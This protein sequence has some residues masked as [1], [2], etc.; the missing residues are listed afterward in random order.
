MLKLLIRN[1]IIIYIIVYSFSCKFINFHTILEEFYDIT[2][3]YMASTSL[4]F[5]FSD[6]PH[7]DSLEKS[8]SIRENNKPINFSLDKEGK[9][10]SLKPTEGWKKNASY[11]F[12]LQGEV[13]IKTG[14]YNTFYI[15]KNFIYGSPKDIFTLETFIE[16]CAISNQNNLTFLFNQQIDLSSFV[17]NFTLT[18]SISYKTNYKG[19][20][21][22][23]I[24]TE[25]WKT[26]IRYKW[27]I[28]N[29]VSTN[30]ILLQKEYQGNFVY[31]EDIEF[32]TVTDVSGFSQ[33]MVKD[34]DS[35]KITFN[36]AMD[37]YSVA[38][39]VNIEPYIEGQL[40]S[41][42]E[43]NVF[44]WKPTTNWNIATDYTLTLDSSIADVSQLRLGKKYTYNFSV[45]DKYLQVTKIDFIFGHEIKEITNLNQDSYYIDF[46]SVVADSQNPLDAPLEL[47]TSINFSSSIP[48]INQS[49]ALDG[50]KL[51]PVF[52]EKAS[53]PILKDVVWSNDGKSL[54]LYWTDVTVSSQDI[55]YFYDLVIWSKVKDLS[56][57]AGDT[58][59][60]DVC[61]N[62]SYGK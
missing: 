21:L 16:P 26:N 43:K 25:N 7:K 1:I 2:N 50:I 35:I 56:N 20:E 11:E 37:F 18:P 44:Y 13:A 3:G 62:F 59:Q 31:K 42:P 39:G 17:K 58:L 15:R 19:Q 47:I 36:K 14:G 12:L 33:T 5:S 29:V 34:N 53:S 24:P 22:T 32:P 9:V 30:N 49:K 4:R 52:P 46:P 54:S 10:F 27:A 40:F 61:I 41:S 8:I 60:E 38:Q 51:L 6:M 23:I 28:K 55:S 45:F 48:L 57:S